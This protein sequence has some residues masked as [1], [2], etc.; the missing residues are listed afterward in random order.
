MDSES[1]KLDLDSDSF[2]LDR[3]SPEKCLGKGASGEVYLA[4]DK[5]LSKAV[6]VK[7]LHHLDREQLI[8]FQEEA[9]ATSKLN[10]P[11]IVDIL[12][13]GATDSGTPYM[14]LEYFPG[15]TL[16]SLLEKRDSIEWS[17]LR[18]I[19]IGVTRALAYAHR[20]GIY[21]RDLT[22][23]NI[24]I[25]FPQSDSNFYGGSGEVRVR[26]IDFGVAKVSELSGR[27]T[28]YQGLTIAGTPGYMSPDVV[29]GYS[30][31]A[32]SEVYSVGCIIYEALTGR[33]P[34]QAD[35]ALEMLGL[36]ASK[37]ALRMSDLVPGS[38]PDD[39]ETIVANCLAKH[40][41]DRYQSMDD[42]LQVLEE[43]SPTH[44]TGG[45]LEDKDSGSSAV[46][47]AVS[48]E[49]PRS[50]R[51]RLIVI[52]I[53]FFFLFS[54][55]TIFLIFLGEDET[56][57]EMTMA[58]KAILRNSE[59]RIADGSVWTVRD[60]SKF[61]VTDDELHVD[62]VSEL[63]GQDLRELQPKR[64]KSITFSHVA[65][66]DPRVCRVIAGA[67][68]ISRLEFRYCD[69]LTDRFL[70]ELAS[71]LETVRDKNSR[72]EE[73]HLRRCYSLEETENTLRALARLSGLKRLEINGLNLGD[74]SVEVIARLPLSMVTLGSI[75]LT[76][77]GLRSLSKQNSLRFLGLRE[78]PL[79]TAEELERFR[80]ARP[81][82]QLVLG[83]DDTGKGSKVRFKT[84]LKESL[85]SESEP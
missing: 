39:I 80:K 6:A 59:F 68:S 49:E 36:H 79:I 13:F 50:I 84:I 21:H 16:E 31:S 47:S 29:N 32:A 14:V 77:R 72:L 57:K 53:I 40:P 48:R 60:K 69:G 71:K 63:S 5:K 8:Q 37:D 11:N 3:Y 15:T 27:V 61:V 22:P 76:D 7:I 74:A 65:G 23:A 35:T 54:L 64:F 51:P 78:L 75:D 1:S 38:L 81:D 28:E 66:F 10:H 26:L 9:R 85:E 44:L 2:P 46:S 58:N 12:D 30:Y 70:L 33:P 83:V 4:L 42:L 19:M 25:S 45:L 52:A 20:Q 34:F 73:L 55:S 43:Q 82:C 24:L 62:S 56:E 18:S 17:E 41:E 67:T